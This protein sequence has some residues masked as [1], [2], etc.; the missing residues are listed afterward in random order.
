MTPREAG[1]GFLP[2]ASKDPPCEKPLIPA[3]DPAAQLLRR[4]LRRVER[5]QHARGANPQPRDDAP[6]VEAGDGPRVGRLHRGAN[7]ENEGGELHARAA[8]EARGEREDGEA[9]DEG[10]AL[11]EPD[12]QGLD[13]RLL[14]GAAVGETEG[15]LVRGERDCS[16]WGPSV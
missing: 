4:H 10:A 14:A 1:E 16:A 12:G 13:L 15:G 7:D 2:V 9:A 3:P 11:L 8:A 6:R 5:D